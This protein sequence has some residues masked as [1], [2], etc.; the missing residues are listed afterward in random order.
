[1]GLG[2]EVTNICLP[3]GELQ[4]GLLHARAFSPIFAT[5]ESLTLPSR[6]FDHAALGI[7]YIATEISQAIPYWDLQSIPLDSNTMQ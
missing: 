6:T 1:M 7:F 5:L 4:Q 2:H 3:Q